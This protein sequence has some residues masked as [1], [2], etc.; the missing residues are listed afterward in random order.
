M[1]M[2]VVTA[3]YPVGLRDEFEDYLGRLQLS[4]SGSA[5]GLEEA[6][7]YSLL[8]GG[9]RIR[10]VLVLASARA[11]GLPQRHVLPLAAGIE[12]IHTFSLIHDDLP[13][14]DDDDLRRGRPTNHRVYGDAVAIL[15]GDAL[16]AEGLRMVL[17][18]D[19]P[20]E[21][22]LRAARVVSRAAG[23]DGLAGGQYL[24]VND[25]AAD[26]QAVL[27]LHRLKTGALLG[28]CVLAVLELARPRSEVRAELERYAAE[29]GLMFQIVDDILDVTATS[30]ETG[31]SSG[32][33]ARNG[34]RTLVAAGTHRAGR[35]ADKCFARIER[36]LLDLPLDTT[37]LLGIAALVRH[38]R[39]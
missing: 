19:A 20:P 1:R 22:T 3:A 27:E 33:D 16:L 31:K 32:S 18:L 29:L 37:E 23:T 10:P 6:M 35:L 14:M 21:R 28:A 11:L 26:E 38:R 5:A 12:L 24:D 25:L 30:G 13:A 39:A 2:P 36:C 4:S 15:A 9:K 8:A 17:E 34:K 7:R